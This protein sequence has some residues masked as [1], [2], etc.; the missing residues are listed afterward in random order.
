MPFQ[1]TWSSE[2]SLLDPYGFAT[3]VPTQTAAVHYPKTQ[4]CW[5]YDSANSACSAAGSGLTTPYADPGKYTIGNVGR[6]TLLGPQTMLFDFALYKTFPFTER[7]NA[8]IR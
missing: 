8:Q 1:A 6:N 5:F 4:L 2:S 3:S 7:V